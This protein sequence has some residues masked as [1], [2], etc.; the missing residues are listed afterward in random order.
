VPLIDSTNAAAALLLILCRSP[1]RG[2]FGAVLGAGG[3]RYLRQ[4]RLPGMRYDGL[5]AKETV[6]EVMREKVIMRSGLKLT[7]LYA[8]GRTSR[9]YK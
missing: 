3:S 5:E 9:R 4:N 8:F 1:L 7:G 2:S 6:C